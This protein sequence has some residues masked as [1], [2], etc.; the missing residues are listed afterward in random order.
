[1]RIAVVLVLVCVAG[2]DAKKPGVVAEREDGAADAA[3]S[4]SGKVAEAS[5]TEA[6]H[7]AMMEGAVAMFTALGAAA[8][9]SGGD[10]AKLTASLDRAMV[11]GRVFIDQAKRHKDDPEVTRRSEAWMQANN[12]RVMDPMMKFA[13]ASQK[14]AGDPTFAAAMERFSTLE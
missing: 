2:C 5:M 13:G 10:C 12:D 9:A 6:E 1:M 8:D 11:E 14:C 3:G 4:G 7:T